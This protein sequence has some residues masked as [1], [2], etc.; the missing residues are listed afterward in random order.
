[1]KKAITIFISILISSNLYSEGNTSDLKKSIFN[2]EKR[3]ELVQKKKDSHEAK[4]EKRAELVQKKKDSHEAK[5]EK[6]AELV[7]K[8]KNNH[9]K[10]ERK[11]ER[12]NK[13]SQFL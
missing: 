1:M 13:R 4:K 5:K 10:K 12:L 6:R 3:A 8:K 9:E 11:L 2:K 7:Q